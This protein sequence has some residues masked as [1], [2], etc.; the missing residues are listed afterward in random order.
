MARSSK[1][2]RKS[3]GNVEKKAKKI[4]QHTARKITHKTVST[5]ETTESSG[6][7]EKIPASAK[8]SIAA[9]KKPKISQGQLKPKRKTGKNVLKEIKYFQKNI[10]FL[11]QHTTIMRIV[12]G[13]TR[14]E[15]GEEFRFTRT[16]FDVL[17]EALEAH[18]VNTL[19]YA[20][21][22]ARHAK[23][24]TLFPSDIK[25]VLRIRSGV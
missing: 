9:I 8:K 21:L 4:K 3:V 16:S 17:Q 2:A 25:L 22:L 18:I 14:E 7:T 12:R 13:I 10:G 5:Q 11:I 1:T 24:V 23:R 15:G 20:N 6:K 19:E